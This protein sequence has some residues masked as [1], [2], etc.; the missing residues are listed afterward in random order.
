MEI[1]VLNELITV[2]LLFYYYIYSNAIKSNK[3]HCIWL[4]R[5]GNLLSVLLLLYLFENIH[6]KTNVYK[7][8]EFAFISGDFGNKHH[9]NTAIWLAKS[10]TI[11][12]CC[13]LSYEQTVS[14][15]EREGILDYIH[16][17]FML[18]VFRKMDRRVFKRWK[19][20]FF[21]V[22]VFRRGSRDLRL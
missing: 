12:K 18:A 6:A 21:N 5:H 8:G 22:C 9:G 2:L 7:T 15:L 13:E 1:S 3:N 17:Y 14:L 16:A 19:Y 11:R 20:H 4:R 10:G